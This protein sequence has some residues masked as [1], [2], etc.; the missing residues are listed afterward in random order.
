MP[1]DPIPVNE[2]YKIL[3]PI[4]T[5][6]R[7]R[8]AGI[9]GDKIARRGV[10]VGEVAP[11]TARDAYLL[12]C[13]LGMIDDQHAAPALAGLDGAHHARRTGPDDHD[14]EVFHGVV[15]RPGLVLGAFVVGIVLGQDHNPGASR[16]IGRHKDA[17]AI[18][19]DRGLVGR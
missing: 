14:I 10:G 12:A 17:N 9:V 4:S 2:P 7:N 16:N 18:G 19:Q 11:P 3:G 13:R 1:S 6:G 15:G 8:K 5:Q